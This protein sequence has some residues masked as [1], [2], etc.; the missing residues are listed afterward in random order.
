MVFRLTKIMKIETALKSHR[1][2]DLTLSKSFSC[3]T[4]PAKA[5][6]IVTIW[7]D[8]RELG[9]QRQKLR[10]LIDGLER[11]LEIERLARNP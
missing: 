10:G 9:L 8:L 1:H 3:E 5:I 4:A 11:K 2:A 6:L 7:S